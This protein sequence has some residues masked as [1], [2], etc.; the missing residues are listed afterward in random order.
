MSKTAILP[1]ITSL[2]ALAGLAAELHASSAIR[3]EHNEKFGLLRTTIDQAVSLANDAAAA[4]E[5]S[6]TPS[7]DAT[8]FAALTAAQETTAMTLDH[9]AD[10]VHELIALAN[11]TKEG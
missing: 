4:A 6:A 5:A 8:A 1:L 10:K 7:P 11:P 9:L 3:S 2:A